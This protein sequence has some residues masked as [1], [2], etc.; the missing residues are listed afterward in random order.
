MGGATKL[1][2]V[3]YTSGYTSLFKCLRALS[4]AAEENNI[5][6]D[7]YIVNKDSL[8]AKE[9]ESC[10]LL[11]A[12]SIAENDKYL[13]RKYRDISVISASTIITSSFFEETTAGQNS[14]VLPR[15]LVKYGD[16]F[17]IEDISHPEFP[18][19]SFARLN[20]YLPLWAGVRLVGGI[21]ET[22]QEQ[23]R[24]EGISV[25]R[26]FTESEK[27]IAKNLMA[28]R[29]TREGISF[30]R[31]DKHTPSYSIQTAYASSRRQV[32][33]YL[34]AVSDESLS[35]EEGMENVALAYNIPPHLQT[36]G[37]NQKVI[38]YWISANKIDPQ[39]RPS[40]V[41][42]DEMIVES[43]YDTDQVI[44]LYAQIEEIIPDKKFEYLVLVPHAR[45]GGADKSAKC[46]IKYL[47]NHG[48][49]LVMT[50]EINSSSTELETWRAI[51]G[52]AILDT[53]NIL[54]DYPKYIQIAALRLLIGCVSPITI[55]VINSQ[56]GYDFA[57]TEYEG[58]NKVARWYFHAFAHVYEEGY[59][60]PPFHNGLGDVYETTQKYITDSVHFKSELE[61]LYGIHSSKI[62][63]VYVPIEKMRVK[64]RYGHTRK[65]LWIGRVCREKLFDV[66][67][68]TGEL[69]DKSG[70]SIE[71]WGPI[72]EDYISKHSLLS[73]PGITYRGAYSD[74]NEV[75]FNDYD[76]LLFTTINEGM[77]NVIL[78]AVAA[79]LFI[80]TPS[81]GGIPEV[82]R[83]GENGMFVPN[84]L[85]AESYVATIKAA[86]KDLIF[87]Q[88][89]TLK[90][91]AKFIM[92][93][94]S[95]ST[96]EKTLNDMRKR[97]DR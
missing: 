14:V 13:N 92:K 82:V 86:Y 32:R 54:A 78:E 31:V 7:V 4:T 39:I 11:P 46:L 16:D 53:K 87:E 75:D 48:N 22:F 42:L 55:D 81:V 93:R 35:T 77:P 90:M 21:A 74:L 41:L 47:G 65:I 40:H 88:R 33:Q 67:L 36:I 1:V 58:V 69:L 23:L 76:M 84:K 34:S 27:L 94:H 56:L 12:L 5:V 68:E 17:T 52:T 2:L 18:S 28:V 79:G 43:M 6:L 97:N 59:M 19:R 66:L 89:A 45:T 61:A 57:G 26:L 95:F 85:K 9:W 25:K 44:E 91:H 3:P 72:D 62:E 71:V 96:Y 8:S 10:I 30:F 15:Y 73:A 83:E 24:S 50:T 63:T 80:I 29:Y 38:E 49:T 20:S 60:I 70:L 51:K 37:I 64:T